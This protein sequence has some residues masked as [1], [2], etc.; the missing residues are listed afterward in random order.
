MW[1]NMVFATW[2]NDDHLL[3]NAPR[4]RELIAID[5]PTGRETVVLRTHSRKAPDYPGLSN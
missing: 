2:V 4:D 5:V 1:D 3:V